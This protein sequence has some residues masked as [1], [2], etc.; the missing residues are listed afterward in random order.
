MSEEADGLN[1]GQLSDGASSKEGNP[2]VE[3]NRCYNLNR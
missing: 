2:A 3:G 1:G